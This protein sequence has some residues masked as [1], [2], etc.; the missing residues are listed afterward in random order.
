MRDKA[1]MSRR[2]FETSRT[3]E[4][5]LAAL[6]GRDSSDH[7]S[8]GGPPK[9]FSRDH[10]SRGVTTAAADVQ[11]NPTSP[12]TPSGVYWHGGDTAHQLRNQ[13]NGRSVARSLPTNAARRHG[14][15]TTD[16]DSVLS[17]AFAAAGAAPSVATA[18][19]DKGPAID[20]KSLQELESALNDESKV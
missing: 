16:K 20:M 12:V 10:E 14:S 18:D 15:D 7:H 11:S 1:E 3:H 6:E 2:R 4:R 8:P 13:E 9:V 5:A 19:G 17:P